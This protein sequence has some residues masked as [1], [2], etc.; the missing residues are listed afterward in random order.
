MN[1]RAS[2]V[3]A[4]I[5]VKPLFQGKS[6]LA[7]YLDSPQRERLIL[8]MLRRVLQATKTRAVE[9]VW[10]VG[11]DPTVKGLARREG[12]AWYQEEGSNV[13][14]SLRR[15]FQR[16][17]DQGKAALYLPGDMPFISQQDVED[18]IASSARLKK[19]VLTPAHQSGGTNGIL[20]PQPAAFYPLLGPNSFHRHLAQCVSLGMKVAI[21]Y[22]RGMG[23]DLDTFDDMKAYQALNP[24]L[25]EQLICEDT[26]CD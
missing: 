21:Y 13:N 1:A 2:R 8:N 10:V 6:R 17:W 7:P 16:V 23:L 5:P 3:I 11:G 22:S 14:E 18:M 25:L 12:A 26:C 20:L 19:A 15:A 9:G 4:V 24:G